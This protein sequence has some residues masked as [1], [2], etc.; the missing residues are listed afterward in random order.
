[1]LD[2]WFLFSNLEHET[3][4]LTEAQITKILNKSL[5]PGVI[6]SRSADVFWADREHFL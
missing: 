5:K 4:S 3:T 1:M 2:I 6:N